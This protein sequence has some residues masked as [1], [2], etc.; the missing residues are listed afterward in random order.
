MIRIQVSN[1]IQL[2]HKGGGMRITG[3]LTGRG[4]KIRDFAPGGFVV[5]ES[6]CSSLILI[7]DSFWLFVPLEP[8]LVLFVKPPALVLERL[9]R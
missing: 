1:M 7:R 9:G 2:P 5:E 3:A 4:M 8:R 6:I